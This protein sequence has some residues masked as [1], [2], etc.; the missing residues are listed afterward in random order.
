[1]L[2]SSLHGKPEVFHTIQGEGK[3]TG[4]PSIFVRLS[5][6]NLH[7]KW[8]DTAFTW[9][10]NN[11]DF[12][13]DA[14]IKYQK[15][16]WQLKVEELSIIDTIKALNCSHIVLT[17][18]EPMIQ[19]NALIEIASKLGDSY[20]FEIETNGTIKPKRK[21]DKLINQYNVSPKLSNSG[22]KKELCLKD[23]ALT[24]FSAS[25]KA[26]FKFVI[27]SESD[28]EETEA[29]L[30]NYNIEPAKV[31]L[32][33]QATSVS[34]LDQKSPWIADLCKMKGFNFS[35]RLHIRLFGNKQGV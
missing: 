22:M 28:L 8:C 2:V 12:D 9:N 31:Y 4:K 20:S 5:G 24:Y 19:Q 18:G 10:W 30:N 16:V 21:F 35:D 17:G 3:N 34:E 32:M 14:D 27:D 7:C 6:C 13:H 26:V 25:E 15:D 33:P 1:M 23:D 11:T 29:I